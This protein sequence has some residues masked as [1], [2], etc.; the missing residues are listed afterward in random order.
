MAQRAAGFLLPFG[1]QTGLGHLVRSAALAEMLRVRG[2][3]TILLDDGDTPLPRFCA[4]AFTR[5]GCESQALDWLVIDH[6]EPGGELVARFGG[7]GAKT[8]RIVDDA[9]PGMADADIILDQNL[10]RA[11]GRKP[12]GRMLLVG[13]AF[14]LLRPAFAR[15][16]P[17]ARPAGDRGGARHILLAPGATDVCGVAD[18]LLPALVAAGF[19]VDVALAGIAANIGAV[20]ALAAAHA[21]EVKLEEDADD[22]A[23]AALL[24]RA[25]IVVGNGG[26]GSWE[27]CAMGASAVLLEMAPDQRAN[28]A[29][30]AEAGAGVAAGHAASDDMPARV[31]RALSALRDDPAAMRVMSARAFAVCDGLGANRVAARMEPVLLRDGGV[32]GLRLA[33]VADC[34]RVFEWQCLPGTRRYARN[35]AVPDWKEHR[36]W[37]ERKLADH[38][39]VMNLVEVDGAPAGVVRLDHAGERQAA[40]LY[41][42]SIF[43]D[44]AFTGRGVATAALQATAQLLPFA[45]LKAFVL[46][47]NETSLRLFARAGYERDTDAFYLPP[48]A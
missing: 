40:P 9:I 7:F 15:A 37:F 29:A 23:M 31:M 1:P 47:E 46:P 22:A 28:I 26:V 13:P 41:E 42:V 14:A 38:R 8:L 11:S 3:A 30:L 17:Y 32:V 39:A 20:R 10:G 19:R 48:R 45:W 6:P 18:R 12:A 36:R 43:L 2:W 35:P 44:P 27:R 24:A 21:D 33:A 5:R 4:G 25:D 34:R 16:R